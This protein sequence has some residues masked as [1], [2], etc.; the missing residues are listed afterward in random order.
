MPDVPAQ[1]AYGQVVGRFVSML[2]DGVD[3][4]NVPDERPLTG[5]VTLL[6][7]VLLVRWPGTVPPRPLSS[8]HWSV[9][10]LMDGCAHLTPTCQ[11][12]S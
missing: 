8:K 1:V 10:L 12:C 4:G 5:N 6:P 7:S 11:E 2:A 3:A 9:E